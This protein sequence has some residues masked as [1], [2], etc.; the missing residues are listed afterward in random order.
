[1]DLASSIQ[2]VLEEI[3]IKIASHTKE[4]T[5]MEILCMAGGV[6]LNCVAN[7]KL[8]RSGLFDNIGFSLQ[9]ETLEELLDALYLLGINILTMKENQ[10]I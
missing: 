9:L 3:M 8:L 6:A 5:G 10:T 4:I 7:G 1:M 2:V